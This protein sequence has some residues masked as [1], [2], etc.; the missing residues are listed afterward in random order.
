MIIFLLISLSVVSAWGINPARQRA[1]YTS[2][3]QYLSLTIEN[4]Q[5]AEG[6]FK[7]SFSGELAS[8]ASYSG[9]LI[10]ISP[11]MSE[12]VVPFTLSLPSDLLPGNNKL[13][14]NLNQIL[15]GSNAETVSSLISLSADIVVDVP[16]TGD[17]IVAQLSVGTVDANAQTPFT[18][19]IVNKGEN[20]VTV[21]ADVIIKGPTN[22]E[23]ANWL[24]EEKT[25]AFQTTGKI[26]TFWSDEKEPGMYQAEVVVH[27]ADK[28]QVLR[29]NFLVGKKEVVVDS[30]STDQFILG[31][32]VSLDLFIR[33]KW[34]EKISDVSAEVFVMSKQGKIL[35]SMETASED[36]EALGRAVLT[37]FWDTK[38]IVV[39]AYDLNVVT[40]FAGDLS[41]QSF[42]IVVKE[43]SL[44]INSALTGQVSK[45]SGDGLSQ[46]ALFMLLLIILVVTNVVI[47]IY[48]RKMKKGK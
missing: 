26:V 48:F 31:G 11:E 15:G 14:L 44:E 1:E 23:I 17:H 33:S 8:Y 47:I 7:V 32:I 24:T 28:V 6:Y 34:N 46:N 13:S 10:Y 36:I 18:I 43:S 38:G 30:I 21:W 9:P 3:Q 37:A 16:I 35:H 45:G 20:A 22:N 2:E 39:G 41:Q 29:K 5:H 25:F 27:Y 4:P 12:Y 40:H 42:P 19:S